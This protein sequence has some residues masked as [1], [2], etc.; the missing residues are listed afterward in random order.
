MKSLKK[1][2]CDLIIANPYRPGC[3]E[4]GGENLW[5]ETFFTYFKYADFENL[6]Y[7]S[8]TRGNH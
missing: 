1:T 2:V 6:C 5:L 3:E 7:T 8:Q 4:G